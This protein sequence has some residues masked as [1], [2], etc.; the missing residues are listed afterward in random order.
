[1]WSDFDRRGDGHN[2]GRD[3]IYFGVVFDTS[4]VGDVSFLLAKPGARRMEL[5]SETQE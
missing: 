2:A 3:C 5:M 4:G 1:M